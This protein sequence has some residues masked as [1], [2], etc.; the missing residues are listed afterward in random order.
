MGLENAQPQSM[1]TTNQ[2]KHTTLPYFAVKAVGSSG[3]AVR[4]PKTLH[5][6]TSMIGS[7]R[8]TRLRAHVSGNKRVY[9]IQGMQ[10]QRQSC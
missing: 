3:A 9:A 4:Q 1:S 7:V 10:C 5:L 8:L 2:H 6:L